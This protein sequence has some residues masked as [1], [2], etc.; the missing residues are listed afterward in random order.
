MKK[1]KR[2]NEQL[3]RA[4]WRWLAETGKYKWEWPEWESNG[5]KIGDVDEYCF[6]CYERNVDIGCKD[7][8][9]IKWPYLKYKRGDECMQESSPYTAWCNAGTPCIRKK[10]AAIIAELPWKNGG[11]K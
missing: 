3:H 11:W 2:T 5:G 1:D 6:A 10:Y 4:L 7:L 9:P 8:C